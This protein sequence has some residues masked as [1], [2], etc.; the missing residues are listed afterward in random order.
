MACDQNGFFAV[1]QEWIAGCERFLQIAVCQ[2]AIAYPNQRINDR[3]AGHKNFVVGDIFA[4]QVLTRILG[5]GKMVHRQM[6]GKRTVGLFWPRRIK[7][8]GTQ[9]RLNMADGNT[10]VKSGQACC[11]RRR[12]IAMYQNNVGLE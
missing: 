8:A 5:R 6:A 4:Q 1:I 3:I 10:L 7:V 11:H 12:G 9:A 2:D